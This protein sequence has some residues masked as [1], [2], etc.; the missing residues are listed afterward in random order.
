MNDDPEHSILPK[1]WTYMVVGVNLQVS[2]LD[3]GEAYLDLTL[4]RAS[5]RRT[6]RFWS[7]RQVVIAEGFLTTGGMI[8]RDVRARGL[9]G[10][11]VQVDDFEATP[12]GVC[13]WA[14]SVEERQS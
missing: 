9:D 4:R 2:P 7:P 6:L 12:G 13:F 1:A 10:L 8:I 3:E 14:R 5:E 11:G